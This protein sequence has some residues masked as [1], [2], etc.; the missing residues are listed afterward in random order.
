MSQAHAKTDRR[1]RPA[2]RQTAGGRQALGGQVARQG[3]ALEVNQIRLVID[4][5]LVSPLFERTNK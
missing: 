1:R 5:S 2:G 4:G 3:F